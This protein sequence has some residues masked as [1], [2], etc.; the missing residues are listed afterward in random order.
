MPHDPP[1]AAE[2]GGD[3]AAT[4]NYARLI[5]LNFSADEQRL[6]NFLRA[7][8]RASHAQGD[9]TAM[10]FLVGGALVYNG[11][12]IRIS[13]DGGVFDWLWNNSPGLRTPP[14]TGLLSGSSHQSDLPQFEIYLQG[15]GVFLVGMSNNFP[16]V[17]G[18]HT[19]FQSEKHAA[20]GN[21]G[22]WVLHGTTYFEH[23]VSGWQQVGA[24]GTSPYSEK[25]NNALVVLAGNYPAY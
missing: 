1:D 8:Y 7:L 2:N 19:W 3:A 5:N 10:P 14:R 11:A 13:G 21:W 23:A 15:A 16:N 17:Q 25:S 22:Q 12:N 6:S 24:F 9:A 4:A 18:P 20:M